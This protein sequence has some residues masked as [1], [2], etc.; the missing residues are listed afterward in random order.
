MKAKR[1]NDPEFWEN[2]RKSFNWNRFG[3][4]CIAGC[5]SNRVND[6]VIRFCKENN[7]PLGS[8]MYCIEKTFINNKKLTNPI[9]VTFPAYMGG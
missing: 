2:L 7:L 1:N 3:G 4:K 8:C 9:H 5:N 6:D